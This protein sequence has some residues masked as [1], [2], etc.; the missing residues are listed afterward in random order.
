MQYALPARQ[1]LAAGTLAA[2]HRHAHGY[3]ALVLAGGYLEAG[4]AGRRAVSAGDVI[5]HEPFEAHANRFGGR[6]ACVLNL[7]LPDGWR[8]AM[9]FMSIADGDA[10]ARLAERDLRAATASLCEQLVPVA[11]QPADWPDLLAADLREGDRVCLGSWARRNGIAPASV[12]RGFRQAFGVSPARYRSEA[13][14]RRA[15]RQLTDTASLADLALETGFA[16]QAHM[17]RAIVALTGTP[18]GRWR[19]SNPFKIEAPDRR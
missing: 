7:P 14:A 17:T 16:D 13:R 8:P 12:S 19:R 11:E 2:R 5:L 4:D 10:I 15:W 18:P 3:A 1:H 6:G 9:S